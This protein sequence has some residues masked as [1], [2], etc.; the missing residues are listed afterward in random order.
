MEKSKNASASQ[1]GTVKD[2]LFKGLYVA[3]P[4][5]LGDGDGKARADADTE[6]QDQ[7]LYAAGGTDTR[8]RVSTEIAP[9]DGRVHDIVG[10]LKEVS[11]KQ[12]KSKLQYERK[13]IPLRHTFDIH[14]LFSSCRIIFHSGAIVELFLK[15]VKWEYEG[16]EKRI[17]KRDS[18]SDNVKISLKIH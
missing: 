1:K 8:Q 17:E 14:F 2:V 5:T 11:Q 15:L 7:E 3:G 16:I 10:L 12:R 13:G 9:D 4:E 18:V 6:A